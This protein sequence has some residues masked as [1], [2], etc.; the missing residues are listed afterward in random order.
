MKTA[1]DKY[2][3][4]AL[5]PSLDFLAGIF[6]GSRLG[7]ADSQLQVLLTLQ[8]SIIIDPNVIFTQLQNL[9][10]IPSFGKEIS[11]IYAVTIYDSEQ[12]HMRGKVFRDGSIKKKIVG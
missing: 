9:Q 4:R 5:C 1:C 7:L 10:Q 2:H 8:N 6:H 11:K 3:I 12:T